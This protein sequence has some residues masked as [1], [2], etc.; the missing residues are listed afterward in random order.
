ML[1]VA[2]NGNFKLRYLF[3][4]DSGA[5]RT[6]I[7]FELASNLGLFKNTVTKDFTYGVEGKKIVCYY[8]KIESAAILHEN[9]TFHEF[10]D[11]EIQV[12][13]SN[14]KIPLFGRDLFRKFNITF[15]E[16]RREII[17]EK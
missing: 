5:D 10:K 3:L 2:I 4:V 14:L 7:P 8:T 15:K 17:L 16:K 11:V 1:E 9:K 13:L 6:V 12:P